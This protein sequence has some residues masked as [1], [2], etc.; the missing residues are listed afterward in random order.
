MSLTKK[1][2]LTFLLVTLVPI[3]VIVWVSQRILVKQAQQQIGARLQEYQG[4]DGGKRM[5]GYS[6]LG[7][8]GTNKAG[9][10]RLVILASY[11]TILKPALET[12]NRMLVVL[13]AALVG[14]AGFGLWLARRLV[15][16]VLEQRKQAEAAA[17]K[18][19][20]QLNAYFNASPTGMGMVD[21]EL[22]YLKV[23]QQLANITGL[24]VEEHS[25][26]TIREVVPQLAYILEPLYQEVFA[27]GKPLLNFEPSG[28]TDSKPGE[29]RDWQISY[30]PLMG[31]EAKP[32]AV[33]TVVTEITE[34]KRAEVELNYAKMAAESASRA[35]PISSRI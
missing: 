1:L 7:A 11:D 17:L 31:K 32:E 6:S 5:V 18:C 33:G 14:T 16:P 30:F 22:R 28:E 23:N 27:T 20:A 4:S 8:Y 29:L 2:V 25:G 9:N 15:K 12:Y 13:I 24:S 34:Q 35:K 19:E 10:W 21:S 26:K 3:G